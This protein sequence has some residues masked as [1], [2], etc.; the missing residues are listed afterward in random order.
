MIASGEA[1][2]FQDGGLLARQDNN[3]AQIPHLAP[4]HGS[5]PHRYQNGQGGIDVH[6][7][8]RDQMRAQRD[9]V[10]AFFS[11]LLKPLRQG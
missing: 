4:D 9:C 10:R 6:Q 3:D 1:Q 5:I 11:F 8:Q 2:Y 7:V